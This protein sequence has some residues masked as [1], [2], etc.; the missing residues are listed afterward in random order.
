MSCCTVSRQITRYVGVLLS[1]C[2]FQ[3]RKFVKNDKKCQNFRYFHCFASNSTMNNL[4]Q[5]ASKLNHKLNFS[6]VS[7]DN[8]LEFI[9][10]LLAN[11]IEIRP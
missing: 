2:I 7:I 3:K 5:T 4:V 11:K 1:M 8:C 6:E 10:N 9:L